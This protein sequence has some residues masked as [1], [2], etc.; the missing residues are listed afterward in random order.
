MREFE[1][2][3]LIN[4]GIPPMPERASKSRE[5]RNFAAKLFRQSR[6]SDYASISDELAKAAALHKARAYSEEIAHG[7]P[8]RSLTRTPL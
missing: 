6:W 2:T 7:E 4:T 3:H 1:K 5:H 8:V